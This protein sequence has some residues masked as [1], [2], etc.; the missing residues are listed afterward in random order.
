MPKHS[1]STNM[2]QNFV[3]PSLTLII[4]LRWL[5]MLYMYIL[6]FYPKYTCNKCF[7]TFIY[8]SD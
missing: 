1:Q 6:I 2:L 4:Y 7:V 5:C 3:G 8:I